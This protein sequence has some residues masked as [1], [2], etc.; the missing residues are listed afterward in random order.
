MKGSVLI[1]GGCG[2]L[3]AHLAVRLFNLGYKVGAFDLKAPPLGGEIEWLWEKTGTKVKVYLGN[4]TDAHVLNEA[5]KDSKADILVHTAVINDLNIL[6][7]SPKVADAVNVG[8]TLNVLEAAREFNIK[9]V[10]YASSI[11]V[12]TTKKYEPMDEEH[13]VLLPDEG[14]TL[15][16]YSSTKLASEAYGLHYWSTFGIDFIALRFSAIY[17]LGMVYP[18]YIKPIVE[19]TVKGLPVYFEGGAE[20][21]RDYTYVEDAVTGIVGAIE[22]K[23]KSH[24]FN[25]STGSKLRRADE[26]IPIVK[27]LN[28][29]ADIVFG[30]KIDPVE[31][32]TA[33]TRGVL[34]IERAKEQLG[35]TSD[36]PLE[37]GASEY[38]KQFSEYYNSKL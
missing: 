7:D 36:Y 37:K 3:G 15:F 8:G 35:F 20:A 21:S 22:S 31:V 6:R 38:Y 32:K 33:T 29:Q 27:S 25:I 14:P 26:L 16:S 2:F 18:M 28:D 1:T 23:P 12:Y 17:G 34:S 4:I 10:V 5:I 30:D 11:S 24:I 9:K 19:N 13:P